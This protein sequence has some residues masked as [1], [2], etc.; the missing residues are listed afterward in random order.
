MHSSQTTHSPLIL[1][2]L[3]FYLFVYSEYTFAEDVI[4][5]SMGGRMAVPPPRRTYM[6]RGSGSDR[7]KQRDG[8]ALLSDREENSEDWLDGPPAAEGGTAATLSEMELVAR[9]KPSSRPAST[10]DL[11]FGSGDLVGL[12]DIQTENLGTETGSTQ[13][14]LAAHRFLRDPDYVD[15]PDLKSKSKVAVPVG[16]TS[17][18]RENSLHAINRDDNSFNSGSRSSSENSFGERGFS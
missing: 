13:A 16:V 9:K 12:D 6:T 17:S 7:N 2:S 18:S 11:L 10:N 4:P 14:M 15:L 3:A 1:V 8:C 5:L